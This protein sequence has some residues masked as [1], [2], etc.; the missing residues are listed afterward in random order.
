MNKKHCVMPIGGKTRVVTWGDD[1]DFPGREIIIM[2]MTFGDFKGLHNKYRV[3]ADVWD[4]RKEMFVKGKV[5]LGK[6]WINH[7]HRRQY[8]AGNVLCRRGTSR[9]SAIS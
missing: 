1:P 9:L 7:P 4:K 6:W 2:A 5:P 8:D 3:I